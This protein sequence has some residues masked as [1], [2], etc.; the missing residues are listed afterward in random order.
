MQTETVT[1]AIAA[2]A[3]ARGLAR[4]SAQTR[5]ALL[6]AIA[7]QLRQQAAQISAINASEVERAAARGMDAA[8]I[9]RLMLNEARVLAMAEEV[10]RIA[11]L[12]DPLA[13]S[14]DH[15][16]LGN[17]ARLHRRRVALGV[18]GVIYEAR[19]NVTI[20]CAALALKTGNGVL[21]RGSSET[22]G[23]N[24]ALLACV[25]AALREHGLDTGAVGLIEN[26]ERSEVDA[27]L[28]AVGLLDLIIPRG[29]AALH[30]RCKHN[31]RVP[32]ITGG[33]GI[34][35]LYVD[36]EVDVEAA[37]KVLINAKVQRPTVCNALDT[38]LLHRDIAAPFLP[39][40]VT[41]MRAHKVALRLDP[42]AYQLASDAG[43]IGAGLNNGGLNN[44]GLRDGG[45]RDGDMIDSGPIQS[46]VTLAGAQDFA[47][48]WLGLV[49]GIAIVSDM[50]AAIAHIEAHSTGHSD[51]ILSSNA[52]HA[53]AFLASVDSAA[54][55]WNASTRFTD[56]AQ[57]ELGSEVAVS[58]QKVHARGPM[59]LEALTSYKWVI[60]G[61][62]HV[63]AD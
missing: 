6:L 2:R 32:V 22:L 40:L 48:E 41:R 44:G 42:S 61:D 30:E 5:D 33:I 53:Q 14:F 63:R 34:C 11:A 28:Q 10:E 55:Y 25:H 9:D 21:L 51:G 45:L 31:A 29:N 1:R 12:A 43:L 46:G 7:A 58:T 26:P 62:Y 16:T 57:L 17:G 56:G 39:Q 54:V 50:A 4:T 23:S 35:H 3:A 8:F 37:L 18:I 24:L 38:V 27:M 15:R 47:T 20:D 36:S 13:A 19:P 60:E 52:E 49:L 59:G